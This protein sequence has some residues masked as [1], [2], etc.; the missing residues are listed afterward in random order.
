M[1]NRKR[2]VVAVTGAS[3]SVYAERLILALL[4]LDFEIH[5]VF[6]EAGKLVFFEE[7]E[8]KI[9]GD[10]DELF[11]NHF[12]V[13]SG[14]IISYLVKDIGA[15]IASGSF[16]TFG[17]VVVPCTMKTL[18]GIANGVSSNLI[19]RAAD[20]TLKERRRLILV[21]RETPF[22][23]IHLKNML[24]C[25]EAG[26]DIVPPNPGFYYKPTT[27]NEIADFIVARILNLL[28]IDNSLLKEWS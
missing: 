20:V 26:A 19:E 17:M 27:I 9:S 22:S 5:L 8:L 14:K 6:S 2:I 12:K 13:T 25:S 1:E 7:R 24:A 4:K 3:G 16:K 21:P 10:L 23:R 15:S 28:G 11:K 18:A